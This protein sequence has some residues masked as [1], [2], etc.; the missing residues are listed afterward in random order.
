MKGA[1]PGGSGCGWLGMGFPF[2]PKLLCPSDPTSWARSSSQRTAGLTQT[3]VQ[4]GE[5]GLG[6]TSQIAQG[7][8]P[9]KSQDLGKT[10]EQ[11]PFQVCG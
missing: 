7:I 1:F 2:F 10:N 4:L 8:L 3:R 11:R 6:V 5:K 9:Q